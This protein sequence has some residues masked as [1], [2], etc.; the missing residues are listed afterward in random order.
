MSPTTN[1]IGDDLFLTNINSV[2]ESVYNIDRSEGDFVG[3]N[4]QMVSVFRS[5]D[6]ERRSKFAAHVDQ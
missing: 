6:S 3:C 2:M 4:K 5:Y 1:T